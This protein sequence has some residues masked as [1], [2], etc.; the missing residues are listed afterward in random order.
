MRK[1]ME[2]EKVEKHVAA[3]LKKSFRSMTEDQLKNATEKITE[4]IRFLID[5]PLCESAA[6]GI[7]FSVRQSAEDIAEEN[8]LDAEILCKIVFDSIRVLRNRSN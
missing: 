6:V 1:A 3:Q 4:I 7:G 2:R 5:M 8:N